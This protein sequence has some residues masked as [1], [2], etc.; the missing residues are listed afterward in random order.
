MLKQQKAW[1]SKFRNQP[2]RTAEGYFASKKEHR[3]WCN[4]KLREQAG[5]ITL[6]Q[7][8]VRFKLAHNGTHICDYI[9]DA[10][11]FEGQK[12]VVFDSKGFETDVFKIKKALMKAL[13]NVTVVTG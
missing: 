8:Q 6:L 13:L 7:R 5:E 2:V 3:D 11:Y 10:V 4:L 1:K 12:R 9:A